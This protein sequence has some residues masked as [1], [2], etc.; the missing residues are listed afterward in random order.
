MGDFHSKVLKGRCLLVGCPKLDDA[1]YYVDKLSQIL[2]EAN[3]HGLTV[4]HMEVPC[5]FGLRKIAELAVQLSG[6]E[7]DIKDVTVSLKGEII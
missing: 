4:V 3:L 2:Q 5:C 6:V 1:Q 7:L